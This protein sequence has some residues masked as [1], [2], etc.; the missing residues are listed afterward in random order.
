METNK[1]CAKCGIDIPKRKKFCSDH[2]K[3][4]F[5]CI[6]RSKEK[7]L[8]PVKKRNK[9]WCYVYHNVGNT[10][11]ERGQGKRCGDQVKGS[12]AAN[13]SYT[14][15]DLREF[16]FQNIE[17]HFKPKKGYPYVP[18]YIRLGDGTRMTKD[19]AKTFLIN[20]DTAMYAA[21]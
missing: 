12:M 2:C 6:K 14:I 19:E 3:W 11:S 16:N 15:E 8:P 9:E 1:T 20:Q 5:N 13:V 17:E 7:D 21:H 18:S 4:W 10:I